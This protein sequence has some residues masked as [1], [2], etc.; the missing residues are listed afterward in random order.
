MFDGIKQENQK[1]IRDLM[2]ELIPSDGSTIGNKTLIDVFSRHCAVEKLEYSD[3]IYWETRAYLIDKGILATGKGR[4]GS[5]FRTK[6]E[7]NNNSK[8]SIPEEED[9]EDDLWSE[10]SKSS[11]VIPPNLEKLRN[12]LLDLSARNR[13]LNFSHS[14][15][16]RFVR[17]VDELPEQLFDELMNE[18]AMRFDPVSEPTEKQLLDAGYLTRNIETGVISEVKRLPNAEEWAAKLGIETSYELPAQSEFKAGKH[19]DQ[20]IQALYFAPELESRLQI[21]YTESR[22]AIEETGANVLYLAMGF[23]EWEES[24]AGKNS[25]RLAPLVL[26]PVRLARGELNR[27]TSTYEYKVE[28]TG[29]DILTNLSLREKLKRDFGIAMPTIG[30]TTKPEAYFKSI[31]ATVLQAKPDWKLRR[32]ASL[33]LFEF[34]KLMMYLDL[35]PN[36][37]Q[38]TSIVDHLLVQQLTGATSPETNGSDSSASFSEEYYIDTLED[39]E[40]NFP[41]IDDADSSQHSAII[42]VLNGQN[43]V[44]EGPPGTGKSQTITNVIA[45]AIAQ[46]KKVLFVAEKSAALEVVKNRLT[47]AGIGDFCLELHSHKSQKQSVVDRIRQRIVRRG[48]FRAPSQLAQKIETLQE[49]KYRLNRYVELLRTPYLKTGLTNHQVLNRARRFREEIAVPLENFHPTLNAPISEDKVKEE[50]SFYAKFFERTAN[51]DGSIKMLGEHPWAGLQVD[52]FDGVERTG[53]LKSLVTAKTALENLHSTIVLLSQEIPIPEILHSSPS[54]IE[55]IAKCL[56]MVKLAHGDEDWE[57]LLSLDADGCVNL[58]QWLN[59]ANLLFSERDLLSTK[60]QFSVLESESTL[61][62]VEDAISLIRK[63]SG[64]EYVSLENLQILLKKISDSLQDAPKI[65]ILLS[66]IKKGLASD[67]ANT[68]TTNAEGLNQLALLMSL[69]NGLPGHQDNLR[70]SI[71][72]L[73]SIDPLLTDLDQ[74]IDQLIAQRNWIGKVFAIDR[75]PNLQRLEDLGRVLREKSVFNWLKSSW[76]NA[77]KDLLSFSRP[78]I[79]FEKALA[80]LMAT[81]KIQ[82]DIQNFVENPIYRKGLK[83]LFL[84][85]DTPIKDYVEVRK[86]YKDVR[87]KCGRGFGPT[88]WVADWLFQIPSETLNAVRREADHHIPLIEFV[89]TVQKE[90]VIQFPFDQYELGSRNLLAHDGIFMQIANDL[91]LS[92]DVLTLNVRITKPSISDCDNL[93]KEISI[94]QTQRRKLENDEQ[95]K[96]SLNHTNLPALFESNERSKL[97]SWRHTV[98]LLIPILELPQPVIWLNLLLNESPQSANQC[99]GR[100]RTIGSGLMLKTTAWLESW[101]DCSHRGQIDEKIWWKLSSKD[102]VELYLKRITLALSRPDLLDHWVEYR[103]LRGR[104]VSLGFLAAV[105]AT[106]NGELPIGFCAAACAGGLLDSW[107]KNLLTQLPELAQF[108]GKEQDVIRFRFAEIDHELKALQ[109]EQIAWEIDQKKIPVGINSGKVKE[110]T[111]LALLEHEISKQRRH[112]PIRVLM[113][114][115]H[116]ALQALMPCFMMS[117]MAVAQY[118]PAGLVNF[119][120]VIMDEASQVRAEEALG[121]FARGKQIVVVGDPKQLPPTNFFSRQGGD[122]EDEDEEQSVANIAE[123]ILDAAMPIF[124]LRRLRWHYRSRHESLIAFSNW[125][126]YESN[127]VVYPS[128]HKESHEFGI[129]FIKVPRG[130]FVEQRNI[131]EAEVVVKAVEHHLIHSPNES[132]GVVTMNLKQKEQIERMLEDRSKENAPLRDAL[133]KNSANDE[134]LFIKNLENV[135]G[136]ERDVIFISATYGP[137]EIGGRV[138]QRFGPING[139]NGWRRLNVLFTRSK[140][141]MHVF[142]SFGTT[143]ILITGTSSRGVK[144]LRDFLGF[145]ESGRMPQISETSREPDS[146]FE[147]SVSE[148][149]GKHG[150]EC[151]PQVGVAG[152][153]IDLAVRD[154][155]LPGRYLMGIECDGASYHSAKSARD[156][157][158]LRQSILEQLGWNIRR[159]WSVDWYRNAALPMASILAELNDLRS[160]AQLHADFASE[161]LELDD[162]EIVPEVREI[163]ERIEQ[164]SDGK[165]QDLRGQ[166]KW[167]NQTFIYKKFPTTLEDARLLKPSMIDALVE[168]RPATKWE[169]LERIPG[170]LRAGISADEGYFLEDVLTLINEA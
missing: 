80:V 139:A 72:D 83:E 125:S 31:T 141:R 62:T 164:I 74:T 64:A 55:E 9:A 50:A 21:L 65:Q 4:G 85:L 49:H 60:I 100:W 10:T 160:K 52:T 140:K 86:W 29:E 170:Y 150:F 13:L 116:N 113:S 149:L 40:K 154:P 76:R 144:A 48:T 34:G 28:S 71:F 111:E 104:L 24:V 123:S 41:L 3:E 37:W 115:G 166:L 124:R 162:E 73:D 135:Q 82:R 51:F 15:G 98:D 165:P 14:R 133:D 138:P 53:L 69:A 117:P 132:L 129:K 169:F 114:R 136:D 168:F 131:E 79:S 44:I 134:P 7:Q 146:D 103:R 91:K 121:S 106:E 130:R 122:E 26:V 59:K 38:G 54:Q 153:F 22:S 147:I 148:M 6:I 45:A 128:P 152:F 108:S 156:R 77:R 8:I 70:N 68:V 112:E 84:G 137:M 97:A 36:R 43:L 11:I 93:C 46:G 63:H 39:V 20:S 89:E 161:N 99:L 143:D 57:L 119:D 88:V 126:F 151:E 145:A 75:L 61:K 92:L 81:E 157:D 159:I 58:V 155:L 56:S 109:R 101:T 105:E 1:N 30:R 47:R 27:K 33:G 110:R 90:L 12:R 95:L 78:G 2:L 35:D 66:R 18:R 16:K 19:D 118:L 120:I 67:R 23:L 102:S 163:S 167:F 127:L 94:W 107:A 17:V 25:T 158:R 32:F 42:D 87:E 5:V 142:S 96:M